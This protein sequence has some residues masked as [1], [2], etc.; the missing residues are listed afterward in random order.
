MRQQNRDVTSF[1]REGGERRKEKHLSKERPILFLL[2]SETTK[3]FVGDRKLIE[4]GKRNQE[5]LVER[6]ATFNGQVFSLLRV[7][8]Q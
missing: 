8:A 7:I 3:E 6:G 4:S 2:R 5:A 1:C